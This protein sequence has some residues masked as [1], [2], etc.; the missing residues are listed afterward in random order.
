MRTRA[1]TGRVITPSG[2]GVSSGTVRITPVA[3]YPAAE[4]MGVL[5]PTRAEY[6]ITDG[7]I[8]GNIV[9]PAI[10]KFEVLDGGTP[11]WVFFRAVADV[12]TPTTLQEIYLED[13]DLPEVDPSYLREGD[14]VLLLSAGTA[15]SG[16]VLTSLGGGVMGWSGAGAGDMTK[17]V[18]DANGDGIVAAADSAPWSGITGKPSTYPP[19]AHASSH[20][21]GGSDVVSPAAIGALP[22][23]GVIVAVATSR[24]LTA[25]D[26]GACLVC[27]GTLTLTAPNSMATG[28]QVVIVN[29]GTGTVTLAAA[30]TLAS[31]G[32]KNKLTSQY[33]A[34]TMIHGGSN[35]WYAFGDLS[36]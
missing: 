26:A 22:L 36:S 20:A 30:G 18:Y 11:V 24:D 9:V 14:S 7:L 25:A 17:A 28:F 16:Q 27:N 8:N 35:T 23:H 29:G 3:P 19:E 10:Y 31:R 32:G 21:S 33:A 13:A 1:L 12:A 4:E 6:T 2:A 15:P 34:A 5:A